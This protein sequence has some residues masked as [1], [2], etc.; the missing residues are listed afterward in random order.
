M[1]SMELVYKLI[2]I[3][4]VTFVA[5]ITLVAFQNFI[6]PLMHHKTIYKVIIPCIAV[7]LFPIMGFLYY[8]KTDNPIMIVWGM[9]FFSIIIGF[10]L[11]IREGNW[12]HGAAIA[13]YNIVFCYYLFGLKKARFII[14]PHLISLVVV[15]IY[16]TWPDAHVGHTITHEILHN[17]YYGIPVIG[18]VEVMLTY[19]EKLTERTTDLEENRQVLSRSIRS[20]GHDLRTPLNGI[21]GLT[22]VISSKYEDDDETKKYTK[23]IN[24]SAIQLNLIVENIIEIS[25]ARALQIKV[26]KNTFN[27]RN[28]INDIIN[29]LD[30]VRYHGVNVKLQSNIDESSLIETDQQIFTR[31]MYN[32]ISNA[33]KFTYEGSVTIGA[34]ILSTDAVR[35]KQVV[36]F[37]VEDTG[38][39][40]EQELIKNLGADFLR[41]DDTGSVHGHGLGMGIVKQYLEILG[42]E[43]VVRS[44]VGRGTIMSFDLE[45]PVLSEITS[46]HIRVE[47]KDSV[48]VVVDDAGVNL[49]VLETI[50]N[51]LGYF[52]VCTFDHPRDAWEFI[53]RNHVDLLITDH[54]MPDIIGT[55]LIDKVKGEKPHVPC[56]IQT[57]ADTKDFDIIKSVDAYGT[58]IVHKPFS[59]DDISKAVNK[60]LGNI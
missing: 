7:T 26:T 27:V 2:I 35:K 9:M 6:D 23:L 20:M 52:R 24:G 11:T 12:L 37:T 42:S 25:K 1:A 56:I 21:I 30:T 58:E 54:M 19:L 22:S 59:I 45:V 31:I 13:S 40:M 4:L 32:L 10:L 3:V 47:S 53:R 50:L 39:G 15:G 16:V 5:S 48:I 34:D 60:S 51:Q 33:Y 29:I 49:T 38:I 28:S 46:E 55:E 43:L 17:L 14:Y 8:K 36:R 44:D 41:A 18:S 57:G